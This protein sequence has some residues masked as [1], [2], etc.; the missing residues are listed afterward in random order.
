MTHLN[1]DE[2][3]KKTSIEIEPN[4]Q[5]Q[6]T[7][8]CTPSLIREPTKFE[9]ISQTL[10][11]FS[12]SALSSP[13]R[14]SLPTSTSINQTTNNQSINR[15]YPPILSSATQSTQDNHDQL[16]S[17][18]W[19]TYQHRPLLLLLSKLGLK[20]WDA[21]DLEGFV[22][23][24]HLQW[25]II[26]STPQPTLAYNLPAQRLPM[27][28][29]AS[30][31]PQPI[32]TTQFEPIS[33]SI[34]PLE[35]PT[36]DI[37]VAV[38]FVSS[39]KRLSRLE[40]LST[41][42]SR[43]VFSID[44]PGI[45]VQLKSNRKLVVVATQYPLSLRLFT[46]H[47][48]V[49]GESQ[50][51]LTELPFSPI[52]DLSPKP[53]T[54]E[55]VFCLGTNRLLAYASNKAP[56]ERDPPIA[57]G[58]GF[59]FS[60]PHQDTRSPSKTESIGSMGSSA[61]T[62]ELSTSCMSHHH[63]HHLSTGS[64]KH[65]MSQNLD[66]ID[67]TARKVGGGI[68]SG[69]KLLTSWGHQVLTN[70]ATNGRPIGNGKPHSVRWDSQSNA[71]SKSAP[72]PHM[73]NSATEPGGHSDGFGRL[74]AFSPELEDS[75]HHPP[76]QL[77][78]A[79][80]TQM[81][82]GTP[83]QPH[84]LHT[85]GP[86]L[87]VESSLA[88]GNVKVIDLNPSS[89]LKGA[90]IHYQPVSHFKPSSE[91]LQFLSFN[92]SSTMLLASSVD[93]HAFHVFEL[94]PAARVGKSCLGAR[95]SEAEPTVWHRYKLV[96][97]FT[98]AG[99]R[100]VV[101]S[102]DSKIVAVAT[103]RG[104]HH[105]FAIHPAGGQLSSRPGT[106][107]PL[108]IL[109]LATSNPTVFQPLSVTLSA[110]TTIKP[111]QSARPPTLGPAPEYEPEE[112]AYTF[113]FLRPR[114][115][116]PTERRQLAFEAVLTP[117]HRRLPA[118]LLF[119]QANHSVL[120]YN[121]DLK[122]GPPSIPSRAVSLP[123]PHS[124]HDPPAKTKA[125]PS[126]LSQLMQ[127]QQQEPAIACTATLTWPLRLAQLHTLEPCS[128]ESERQTTGERRHWTSFAEIDTFS[129][130]I[131]ILPRSI[132]TSHQFHFF[133]L[134]LPL[135][136]DHPSSSS[137][138]KV[139]VRAEVVIEP[140]ALA[141]GDDDFLNGGPRLARYAEPIRSAVETVLDARPVTASAEGFPN[142]H[143]G[144]T[145]VPRPALSEVVRRLGRRRGL[146]KRD[147]H[148]VDGGAGTVPSSVSFDEAESVSSAFSSRG[149]DEEDDGGGWEDAW[150]IEGEEEEKGEPR[151]GS[152]EAFSTTTTDSLS[153]GRGGGGDGGRGTKK[154]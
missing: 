106:G 26:H 32:P 19:F 31:S 37:H 112:A 14:H 138:T 81:D 134:G 11:S 116:P 29:S 8:I 83:H 73:V 64:W 154:R 50:L 113:T 56:H 96:R 42:T 144:R 78:A 118:G 133:H 80:P 49:T 3:N 33:A 149:G 17:S 60:S 2:R 76:E 107:H 123:S 4:Q 135:S 27:P 10:H 39:S 67:E 84:D 24:S 71:F 99:V 137:L 105:L 87:H 82:G 48:L 13:F 9:S 132:Y 152:S 148:E 45:A 70:G 68:L 15:T 75:I 151:E 92:P 20:I 51:S 126:G 142:G 121:L 114:P 58:H 101:W 86:K 136:L 62:G 97:G 89:A 54:G 21:H 85:S 109:A 30:D 55:P 117:A 46:V 90:Q 22:Q 119:D 40:L 110:L 141:E 59:S 120:L 72:L 34:L 93:A 79:K 66:T 140:G 111:K 147:H 131:H 44:I 91:P 122:H 35:T 1:K 18:C 7:I 98:S 47:N 38:L 25:Q 52:L 53:K 94:R 115:Y 146:S 104:T 12:L 41:Q 153:E 128:L 65:S 127:Q 63:H 143:P 5:L 69:A 125:I 57:T 74:G 108:P 130:S 103:E 16:I 88:C 95:K 102:W 150:A 77:S 28:S 23:L 43:L 124:L 100:E 36:S 6:S 145:T 129:R 139:R 61:G